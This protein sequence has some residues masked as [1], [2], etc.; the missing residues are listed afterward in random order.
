MCQSKG[1]CRICKGKHHSLLHARG[2]GNI[3]VVEE[4]NLNANVG[5]SAVA[6]TSTPQGE[7]EVKPTVTCFSSGRVYK[8]VL[9]ATALVKALSKNGDYYTVRAL[10]DQGSQSSFVTEGTVQYL[11]LKKIPVKGH[12]TGL[13]GGKNITTNSMVTIKMKSRVNPDL[14]FEVN[15][16]VLKNITSE[17]PSERVE[18]MQWFDVTDLELA[19][20][21]FHVPNK[22]DILLGAEVY[23]K[24]L[25]EG[26]KKSSTGDF[27]AQATSLGW[28]LSGVVP[29]SLRPSAD[30]N[31]LHARV[32]DDE[33]LKRFWEL[34][35]DTE[36]TK[37]QRFTEEEKRCEEHFDRTIQRDESGRYIARLPF[38]DDE[39]QL[40][41]SEKICHVRLNSLRRK[42]DKDMNLKEKY[43]EVF[44]EY[45]TLDHMEKVPDEEKGN[46]NAVYLPHHAVVRED[47]DSSKRLWLEGLEWDEKVSDEILKDWMSYREELIHLSEINIPRWAGTTLDDQ[48]VELHGFCDASQVAYAAVVYV[49]VTNKEGITKTVTVY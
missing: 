5:T 46:K 39:I 33:L 12:I 7:D 25:K 44:Y 48:K 18:V 31:V 49:R 36:L 13:G 24:V 16:Y 34:E 21:N 2:T 23:S 19:D 26:I 17:L 32:E 38:K 29:S 4:A 40:D 8:Q 43:S 9:L 10:L 3:E 27:I 42:L 45:L 14:V 28:I 47:K 1:R 30:I 41:G 15:A 37:E 11:G 35:K 22:V 20:P 6:S